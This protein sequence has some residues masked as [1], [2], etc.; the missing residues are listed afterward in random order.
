MRLYLSTL[1][2]ITCRIQ[3][4]FEAKVKNGMY[5]G[6]YVIY[7]NKALKLALS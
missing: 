2:K 7:F 6:R 5:I 3:N 4:L 1:F